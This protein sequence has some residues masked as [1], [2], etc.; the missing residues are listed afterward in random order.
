MQDVGLRNAIAALPEKER[1][2]PQFVLQVINEL[3]DAA[4]SEY[5]AAIANGKIAAAIEYQDSRGFVTYADRLLQGISQQLAASN[6]E[7]HKAIASSMSELT[8]TWPAVIPPAKPVNTPPQVTQLI[9]TIE[10][11]SQKIVN[12]SNTSA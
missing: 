1:T 8:K 2:S 4:N 3:L 9:K 11:N 10:Q 6:P 12:N 7:A 5:G